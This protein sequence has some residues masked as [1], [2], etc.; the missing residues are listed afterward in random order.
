MFVSLMSL[1]MHCMRAAH[2][3][4]LIQLTAFLRTMFSAH[5]DENKYIH[6]FSFCEIDA[7]YF[8]YLFSLSSFLSFKN[9]RTDRIKSNTA[10]EPEILV[11][12]S[13]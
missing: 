3:S 7:A 6:S 9:L 5:I 13:N 12:Y 10:D 4:I 11:Q 8:R 1:A 2:F